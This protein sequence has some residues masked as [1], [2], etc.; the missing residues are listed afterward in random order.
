LCP[1][2][3]TPLS[4]AQG[5]IGLI[6]GD[7][8]RLITRIGEGGMGTVYLA[9]HVAL[10][11]RVAVK[12]LRPEYSRDEELVRRFEQEARAASQ[13]GHENIVDVVDF[14]RTAGGSLYF[15]ME[16]LEGESLARLIHREGALPVERALRVLAQICRA[17]GAAHARGVVHRDLKP[18]NVLLVPRDDGTDLVKVL[19]F[20]ISKTHGVP[21]GGR[22]TRAGSIIG[23]PE[24]M[25]PEQ[26]MATAVDHRCDVYAFG[27]LAYEM[28]TGT[29]PFHGETPL[30]TLLKH[31]GEPPE[32]PSRRRPDLPPEA[33][34]MVLKALVK[35]PE[36]RQQDM[37]EVAA[38]L[39]RALA[40]VG[41]A[42]MMTPMKGMPPPPPSAGGTAR[43]P[44]PRRPSSRG[45]TV[46]LEPDEVVTAPPRRAAPPAPAPTAR[47]T[48]PTPPPDFDRVRRRPRAVLLGGVSAAALAVVGVATGLVPLGRSLPVPAAPPAPSPVATPAAT[49]A[50][51]VP[52]AAP[53]PV[54]PSV[55]RFRVTLRSVPPGV[56]VFRG[57]H[58]L[59]AT[60]LDVELDAGGEAE[61]RFARS[62]YRSLERRVRAG[63][64]MVEVRLAKA[65]RRAR[66]ETGGPAPDEQNPY[67]KL[68]DLKPDPFH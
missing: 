8:Y 47:R 2:D 24:Y 50:S 15:V 27:V 35:R 66:K 22:I 56:E 21:D 11:K 16:V 34:A 25:A 45:E 57:G 48:V 61:Y 4:G 54:A 32:P 20:G 43:F 68:E 67:T 36:G 23:T 12:V 28:L 65:E 14:G 64:G 42:P 49:L 58:R 6:L 51:A 52:P 37:S 19:D 31:Q 1:L 3:G 9:E 41:L 26:A 7:R 30:A 17:L 59:G 53:A 46:A 29:L 13:V 33:E 38:D 40:A 18:E 5:L 60:P 55:P 62:G 39:S 10:G 44:S 63:E